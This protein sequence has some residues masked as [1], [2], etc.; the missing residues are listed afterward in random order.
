MHIAGES[1]DDLHAAWKSDFTHGTVFHTEDAGASWTS[2][3]WTGALI[4]DIAC[5]PADANVLYVAQASGAPAARSDDR[6][7]TFTS[8]D[9]GLGNAGAPRDLAITADATAPRLLMATSKGSYATPIPAGVTDR[10][11]ADG[12]DGPATQP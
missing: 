5:D 1:A 9:T 10:I 7:V 11:F 3:N 4:A 2:T 12:F 8:F 6:G